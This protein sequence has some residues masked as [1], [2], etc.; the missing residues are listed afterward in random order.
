MTRI[1]RWSPLE[2]VLS[3]Q[4]TMNNMIRASLRTAGQFEN[5]NGFVPALDLSENAEAY[6]IELA[7]PGLKAEQLEIGIENNVLTIKGEIK[8]ETKE[9]G[10]TYHRVE[11]RYGTF[12]RSLRL[13]NTVNAE[14]IS[15]ELNHGVLRLEIPKAEAVKPRKITV[16]LTQP[17]LSDAS[18][19]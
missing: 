14:A 13:P 4:D 18:N 8:Q 7:V 17:A 19:N 1:T 2:D 16:N 3:M 11:R 12:T 9:E 10:R 6:T 5:G 15:A